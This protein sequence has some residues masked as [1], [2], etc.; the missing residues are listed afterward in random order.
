[1]KKARECRGFVAGLLAVVLA[2]RAHGGVDLVRNGRAVSEIVIAPGAIQAVKLAA[3]DLQKHL[4]LMSG[5]E[6]PIVAAPS[7]GVPSRV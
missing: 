3:Q 6:L 7:P 2:C 1:M 5:A 4:R